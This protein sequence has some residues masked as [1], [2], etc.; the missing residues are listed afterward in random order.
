MIINYHNIP[1]VV[2]NEWEHEDCVDYKVLMGEDTKY[3]YYDKELKQYSNIF[4][5]YSEDLFCYVKRCEKDY[6]YRHILE[7]VFFS[8]INPYSIEFMKNELES[9]IWYNGVKSP[10]NI[11]FQPNHWTVNIKKIFDYKEGIEKF[12]LKESFNIADLVHINLNDYKDTHIF[13]HGA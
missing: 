2:L 5:Y 4:F 13:Y 6:G 9:I 8:K 12:K 7:P 11:S 3:I 10:H 1:C